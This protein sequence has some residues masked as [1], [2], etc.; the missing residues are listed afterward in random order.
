MWDQRDEENWRKGA[1][2]S[3]VPRGSTVVVYC[4]KGIYQYAVDKKT[5]TFKH[6]SSDVVAL[7]EFFDPPIHRTVYGEYAWTFVEGIWKDIASVLERAPWE[8]S[9]IPRLRAIQG[10][11]Y[12]VLEK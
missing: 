2:L 9:S 7:V 11:G 8:P 12:P 10:A 6:P 4:V 1:R 5:G 3:V